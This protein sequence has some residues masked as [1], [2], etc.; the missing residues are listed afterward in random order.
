MLRAQQATR[1]VRHGNDLEHEY[2]AAMRW[3]SGNAVSGCY[4]CIRETTGSYH[5]V[6]K[7]QN[8]EEHK[9]CHPLCA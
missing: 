8:V 5:A 6:V 3:R 9:V 1:S 4:G 2:P 7:R